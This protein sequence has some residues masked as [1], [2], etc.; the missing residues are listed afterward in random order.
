MTQWRYAWI[1]GKSLLFLHF[2]LFSYICK[3]IV[4]YINLLIYLYIVY[5]VGPGCSS[6]AFGAVQEFSPF[7]V[8]DHQR[9]KFNKSS[10]NQGV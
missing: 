8:D 1:H 9:L 5:L 4:R 7:L 3:K 6:I 10:W 2:N